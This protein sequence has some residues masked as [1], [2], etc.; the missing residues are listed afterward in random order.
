MP[1]VIREATEGA[2]TAAD[3]APATANLNST[4]PQSAPPSSVPSA[5][6]APLT[7]KGLAVA[8]E[9]CTRKPIWCLK[10]DDGDEFEEC[11]C[12]Q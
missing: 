3:A 8:F 5:D 1:D 7:F 4:A 2:A 11:T 12:M 10:C 6:D 9:R